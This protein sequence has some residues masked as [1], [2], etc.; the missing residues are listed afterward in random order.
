MVFPPS[1]PR[2]R[3][4]FPPSFRRPQVASSSL[5]PP[6]DVPPPFGPQAVWLPPLP[7]CGRASHTI[8]QRLCWKIFFRGPSPEVAPAL[9]PHWVPSPK[10]PKKC[11]P[12]HNRKMVSPGEHQAPTQGPPEIHGPRIYHPAIQLPQGPIHIS[13]P[14]YR[15]VQSTLK[16]YI[17]HIQ[18]PWLNCQLTDAHCHLVA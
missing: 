11:V 18:E 16:E 1:R 10:L 6:R 4:H 3:G 12:C 9:A 2:L 17:V 13:C 14:S 5:A 15:F 7:P 8:S